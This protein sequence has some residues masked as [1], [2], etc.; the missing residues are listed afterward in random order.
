MGEDRK[1]ILTKVGK[2]GECWARRYDI[3]W[4]EG[5]TFFLT[6]SSSYSNVVT[7]LKLDDGILEYFIQS[8]ITLR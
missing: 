2:R 7:A 1:T 5:S 3:G 6:P 4:G 8:N